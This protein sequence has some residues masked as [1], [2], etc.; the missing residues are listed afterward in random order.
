MSSERD[1]ALEE[2]AKECERRCKELAQKADAAEAN[3]D[4]YN[5]HDYI[6][7]WAALDKFLRY[8]RALHSAP[9]ASGDWV[10]S[11]AMVLA[12]KTKAQ[13]LWHL[14]GK[15]IVIFDSEVL[16]VLE[17]ALAAAPQPKEAPLEDAFCYMIN[18]RDCMWGYSGE[19]NRYRLAD[20][21]E[22][23]PTCQIALSF[24]AFR[25]AVES[26]LANT[27]APDAG[28]ALAKAL[29]EWADRDGICEASWKTVRS[30][31]RQAADRLGKAAPITM[32][33]PNM[34]AEIEAAIENLMAARAA[35]SAAVARGED[36]PLTDNFKRLEWKK[37][38]AQQAYFELVTPENIRA[39]LDATPAL[40]K[41][42]HDLSDD[43]NAK[44]KTCGK[45]VEELIDE[46]FCSG[47]VTN[48]L[49]QKP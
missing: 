48:K 27:P 7:Q 34:T 1:R 20:A 10:I 36:D 49:E 40:V 37:L 2:A 3:G 46:P 44:C 32:G 15:P 41:R 23:Y 47:P 38:K 29:S 21:L 26:V 4:S 14:D 5:A 24:Y 45:F 39:L 19:Q 28:D 13:E 35:L 17:A 33:R 16:R 42:Q 43:F 22:R 9:A 31:M 11:S 12:A 6:E 25:N 30:L 18:Q 8:L